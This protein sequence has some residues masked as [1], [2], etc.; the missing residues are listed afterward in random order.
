[1]KEQHRLALALFVSLLLAA[2]AEPSRMSLPALGGTPSVVPYSPPLTAMPTFAI[3]ATATAL[4]TPTMTLPPT[5]TLDPQTVCRIPGKDGRIFV[6]SDEELQGFTVSWRLEVLRGV[7]QKRYPG[8]ALYRQKLVF[9]G[10]VY[11]YDFAEVVHDSGVVINAP[12]ITVSPYV[13]MSV[14]VLMYG[15]NPPPG[16]DAW[17]A[18]EEITGFI[19][20]AY[21]AAEERP[22]VWRGRFAN[23]GSYVTYRL[24]KGSLAQ[25][26]QW[27]VAY[28][29]LVWGAGVY[30]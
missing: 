27:C 24:W 29:T 6:I 15:E 19:K 17:K 25:L 11:T 28:Y 21:N 23:V 9:G 18:A 7:I 16:F 20:R 12:Y 13:T 1:M 4:P 22:Q 14:L 26:Q 10:R 30:R 3:T 8:W 2:C 5:A